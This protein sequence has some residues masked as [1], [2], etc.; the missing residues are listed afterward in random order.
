MNAKIRSRVLPGNYTFNLTAVDA[1]GSTGTAT[2]RE[3]SVRVRERPVF[4]RTDARFRYSPALLA[5]RRLGLGW[6]H[7]FRPPPLSNVSGTYFANVT[8]NVTFAVISPDLGDDVLVSSATGLIQ[9]VPRRLGNYTVRLVASDGTRR[10]DVLNASW[11]FEVLP[12]DGAWN[13]ANGPNGE[14]CS[15]GRSIEGPDHNGSYTCDCSRTNMTGPNCAIP[16]PTP[17]P[18]RVV[19]SASPSQAATIGVVV[20]ACVALL[21]GALGE[22]G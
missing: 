20:G 12:P 3:W 11:Q 18:P 1:A 9:V 10:I 8:G 7:T 21:G 14:G 13:H 2:I 6:T 22:E 19:V 15:A 16:R 5:E 4:N 17:A